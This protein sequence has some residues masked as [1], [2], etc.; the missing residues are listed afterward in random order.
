MFV[1]PR[2]R[3]SISSRLPPSSSFKYVR[4]LCSEVP[5]SSASF[6]WPG[7]QASS[8]HAYFSSIAYASLAPTEISLLAKIKFGTWVKPCRDHRIGS[9]KFDVP[10]LEYGANVLVGAV[11]HAAIIPHGSN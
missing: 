8:P 10:L 3:C 4:T 11:V 1:L 2:P 9:D 7:K 5:I 6:T